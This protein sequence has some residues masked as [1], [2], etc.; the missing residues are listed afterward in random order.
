MSQRLIPPVAAR[1]LL[2]ILLLL[3]VGS[4]AALA[5]SGGSFDLTWYTVDGGGHAWSAGAGG[6]FVLGGTIGQPDAGLLAGGA[7]GL[8]GG[9]W[10]G[11]SSPVHRVYLPVI[12]RD[13]P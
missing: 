13:F 5:Q 7:F 11:G 2:V 9:F 8:A 4:A 1:T 12:V 6:D 10:A 3:A